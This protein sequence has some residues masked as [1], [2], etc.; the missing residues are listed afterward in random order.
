MGGE[1][2]MG[3]RAP[4]GCGGSLEVLTAPGGYEGPLGGRGG[5]LDGQRAPGAMEG[6]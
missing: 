3:W 5:S 1:S 6:P 4:G 2:L